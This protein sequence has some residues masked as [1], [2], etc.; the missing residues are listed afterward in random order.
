MKVVLYCR[1]RR[2]VIGRDVVGRDVGVE[3]EIP[4]SEAGIGFV[5]IDDK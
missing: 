5:Y 2:E 3:E 4:R 1:M